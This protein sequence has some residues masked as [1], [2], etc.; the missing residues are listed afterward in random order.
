MRITLGGVARED[1]KLK[2]N[3][4]IWPGY[5]P[6]GVHVDKRS[7]HAGKPRATA[8]AMRELETS[9]AKLAAE[10]TDALQVSYKCNM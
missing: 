3:H 5:R 10:K 9:R 6:E 8:Q 4:D 1:M 2:S 7:G